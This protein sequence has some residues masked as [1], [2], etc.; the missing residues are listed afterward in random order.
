L[1]ERF[2]RLGHTIECAPT[3]SVAFDKAS[4]AE[5]PEVIRDGRFVAVE[6]L[7]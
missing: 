3:L 4:V 1:D 2:Q 6:L 7:D 5:F